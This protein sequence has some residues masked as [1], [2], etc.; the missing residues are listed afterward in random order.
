[1]TQ[2]PTTQPSVL[3]VDDQANMTEILS[4]QLGGNYTVQI[5]NSG[6]TALKMIDQDIDVVLLDRRMPGLSGDEVLQRIK[7]EGCDCRV[8]IFTAAIPNFDIIE[9][10]FDDY[11]CKPVDQ[12]TLTRV[13]DYQLTL[14]QSPKVLSD[15][16]ELKL[17]QILIQREKTSSELNS[18][19]AYEELNQ[20]IISYE[21]QAED[22]ASDLDDFESAFES[23]HSKAIYI[24]TD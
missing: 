17:K 19:P 2:R 20:Q 13:I 1:M 14:R 15:L 4:I 23:I 3:V 22:L 5:A 12:Q 24:Q 7:S 6:T 9:L 16:Y 21:S 11:I 10:P 8:I 18:S